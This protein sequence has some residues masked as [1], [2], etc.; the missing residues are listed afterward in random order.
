MG[1]NIGVE[2]IVCGAEFGITI[3]RPESPFFNS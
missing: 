1:T 3:Y 2:S